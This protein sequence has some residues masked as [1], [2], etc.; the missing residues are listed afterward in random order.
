MPARDDCDLLN[1]QETCA[2]IKRIRPEFVFHLAGEVYGI[3][4][5]MKNK[6]VSFLHNILINTHVV[7][8]SHQS[9]VRKIVSMGTGAVYPYPSPGLPLKE[10]MIFLGSPHGAEDSYAQAKRAMLAQHLAYKESYNMD[11]AFVVSANIYGPHDRFNKESG[12]VTPSLSRKFY[13]ASQNDEA[14]V[15]WGDGSAKRDFI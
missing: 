11:Y 1:F 9:G 12:H 2:Y 13:E 14:I 10:T 5:N 4:G 6:A 8:A 3:M 7:E 15:V